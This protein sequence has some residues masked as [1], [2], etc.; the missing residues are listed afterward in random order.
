MT[1]FD[2]LISIGGKEWKSENHHRIYFNDLVS[3]YGL[4]TLEY[5]SG[6]VSSA[7]LKGKKI[8][9]SKASKIIDTLT[10]AKVYYDL[11]TG[12]FHGQRIPESMLADITERIKKLAGMAP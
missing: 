5:K 6:N 2:S 8:S 9:N 11:N 4:V 7:S 1:I 3:L 10:F 12:E